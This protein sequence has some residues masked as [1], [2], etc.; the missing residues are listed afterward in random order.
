MKDNQELNSVANLT[1]E[2]LKKL[3][4]MEQNFGYALVAY[5]NERDV[6]RNNR[7]SQV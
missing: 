5:E 2:E 4:Q 1:E 7:T 3:E 6:D